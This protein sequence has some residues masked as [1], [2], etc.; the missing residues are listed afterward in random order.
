MNLEQR[1]R[2]RTLEIMKINE[3]LHGEVL[4]RN[5]VYQELKKSEARLYEAQHIA[6]I[7]NWEWNI[8]TDDI[9]WSDQIYKITG[10][11]PSMLDMTFNGMLEIVIQEDRP[12]VKAMIEQALRNGQ[13]YDIEHRVVRGDGQLRYIHQQGQVEFDDTGKALRIAGTFQ[14]ITQRYKTEWRAL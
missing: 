14:D 8:A 4:E 9:I 3:E 1:V 6:K 13:P 11:D 12:A 10:I 5:K 2:E 7:G